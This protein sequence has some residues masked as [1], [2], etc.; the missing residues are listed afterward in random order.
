M[1]LAHLPAGYLL[2]RGLLATAA[3]LESLATE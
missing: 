2:T 1:F 3:L